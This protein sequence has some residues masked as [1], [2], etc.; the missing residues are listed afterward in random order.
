MAHWKELLGGSVP[1]AP[2]YELGDAL[3]NPWLQTIGMRDEVAHPDR[4]KLQILANP[5]KLDGER[6]PNRAAPLLGA[7]SDDILGEMGLSESEIAD[8]RDKGVV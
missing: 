8:L 2:V 7:D 5:I 6:M 1:V 4:E 3:D